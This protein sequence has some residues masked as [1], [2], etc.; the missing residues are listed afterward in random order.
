VFDSLAFFFFFLHVRKHAHINN[1]AIF[2]NYAK[3]K[4]W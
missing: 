3:E 1:S 4:W 2:S